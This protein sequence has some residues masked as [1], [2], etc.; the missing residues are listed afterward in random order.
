MVSVIEGLLP[1]KTIK[2]ID[3][4]V[5]ICQPS[6]TPVIHQNRSH[7]ISSL[8]Q[9]QRLRLLRRADSSEVERD[10]FVTL[11]MQLAPEL[12][13][14][15]R[16]RFSNDLQAFD[17]GVVRRTER[18]HQVEL[19]NARNAVMH[20]GRLTRTKAVDLRQLRAHAA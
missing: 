10:L 12:Q 7:A 11:P 9:E 2:S 18:D 8:F 14:Q 19:G 15:P 4:L 13:E 16:H 5:S 20:T 6:N 3:Q 1:P 17:L